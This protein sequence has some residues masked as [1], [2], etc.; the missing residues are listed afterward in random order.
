MKHL[1]KS[2][3]KICGKLIELFPSQVKLGMGIYCSRSCH[4]E[5]Q[6]KRSI[7]FCVCCNKKYTTHYKSRQS[8]FCCRVCALKYLNTDVTILRKRYKGLCK[9][10]TRPEKVVLELIKDNN[11]PYSYVGDGTIIIS[12]L[13][14]DFIHKNNNK[15]IEVFGD[16][17]HRDD[18]ADWN[19]TE[20]GRIEIF[21]NLGYEILILW[22]TDIK[23]S[24]NLIL[25][26]IKSF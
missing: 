5:S 8:K 22:E 2:H 6:R 1:I 20:K 23:K 16:Y 13:N 26:R 4:D 17:W 19:R 18:V 3:C 14:P 24:P 9:K 21:E 12:G 10:P 15:V 7:K 11:L 25:E